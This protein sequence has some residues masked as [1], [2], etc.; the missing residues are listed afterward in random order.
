MS[1]PSLRVAVVGAGSA[2]L[3]LAALLHRQGHRVRVFEKADRLR[4]EGCGILL[5]RSGVEA[6]A[7]SGLEGLLE[8]FLAQG[9]AV[10]R[11]V[12]R[13]LRGDLIDSSPAE[14]VAGEL[15]SL[16]LH[17][18]VILEALA[19]ALPP[20]II[21]FNAEVLHWRQSDPDLD[22]A[23]VEAVFRQGDLWRGDLLVGADG[24]FSRVASLVAPE[25]Q[26]NYLGD[27]VWRGVV[28]D[29]SFCREG[30]FFVYARGRGV[31]ANVFDLGAT[32]SEEALTHWG[33][34]QEEPLPGER[35]EQRRL[36]EEP[37]PE[38]ALA[39]VP[40]DL[41]ALIRSTPAD[42]VVAN[43]SFDINP[44]PRL[45]Q[46]RVV[47]IGD[48]AH[49]MSS[50]QARGMTAGLE[51]AVALARLLDPRALVASSAAAPPP[52]DRALSAWERERLPVVHAYQERSR[53]VS[54]RTGRRRPLRVRGA[55]AAPGTPP[56]ASP[57]ALPPTARPPA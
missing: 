20:E 14:Q 54:A 7:A 40:A 4:A 51:D 13:N 42:A 15:P 53:A 16:L 31:Y 36:L 52:V 27:R 50:S 10:S 57:G 23:P 19:S 21:Q 29:A 45:H 6:I 28:A 24:L 26:L 8:R 41:A 5:V 1:S 17:R 56:G 33:V 37:V 43:W 25:R 11:F 22:P 39:K 34:F 32:A 48:A 12:V 38:E 2:G 46:G 49:A 47:L 3:L 55:G 30:E 9:L 44:L 18:R 35:E